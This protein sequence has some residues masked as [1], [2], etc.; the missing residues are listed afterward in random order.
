ME[1]GAS[2]E[3]GRVGPGHIKARLCRRLLVR[4]QEPK[5]TQTALDKSTVA[6]AVQSESS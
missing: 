2:E 3:P 5:G 4:L 1:L 6:K